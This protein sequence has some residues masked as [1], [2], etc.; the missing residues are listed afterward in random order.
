MP[1][2]EKYPGDKLAGAVGKQFGMLWTTALVAW[3]EGGNTEQ[4]RN[5]L[6]NRIAP[7]FG[8]A[9]VTRV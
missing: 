8:E 4:V 7:L 5:E 9:F 2:S 3:C 1:S 6:T